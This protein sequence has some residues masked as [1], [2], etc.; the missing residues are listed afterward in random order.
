MRNTDQI[1][2]NCLAA[3][4][5]E[6]LKQAEMDGLRDACLAAGPTFCAACDGRCAREANTSA[7]LGDLT[8]LLTYHD[9][10]GYRGEARRLYE[11]EACDVF[12]ADI[13]TATFD[14]RLSSTVG[15]FLFRVGNGTSFGSAT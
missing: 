9:Q 1:R 10:Y 3:A 6:P 12:S 11:E 7:A 4:N 8:R 15:D 5:F 14:L 13:V 2:E